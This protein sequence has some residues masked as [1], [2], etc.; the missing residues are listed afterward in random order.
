MLRARTIIDASSKPELPKHVRLQ[1]NDLRQCWILQAPERVH[2][3]DDVSL[4]ILRKCDGKT[5]AGQ[6][7]VSLAEEYSAPVA[8]VETDII[9]FLQEWS[10]KLLI[11]CGSPS[12]AGVGR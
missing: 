9:A 8:D 10:D 12:G 1:Y 2:W 7:A 4:D 3:P 5:S 6:I 11:R